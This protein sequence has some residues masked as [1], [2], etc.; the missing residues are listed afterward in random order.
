MGKSVCFLFFISFFCILFSLHA[1]II[2]PPAGSIT[3]DVLL[4]SSWEGGAQ[5]SA[6]LHNNAPDSFTNVVVRLHIA[7]QEIVSLWDMEIVNQ[8]V[9]FVDLSF[10]AWKTSLSENDSHAFGFV[11]S[12]STPPRI[13]VISGTSPTSDPDDP[14]PSPLPS[15]QNENL[16]VQ[17]LSPEVQLTLTIDSSWG[18]GTPWSGGSFRATLTN[19]SA[20]GVDN[21]QLLVPFG[22]QISFWGVNIVSQTGSQT[23]IALPDYQPYIAPHASFDFGF[24]IAPLDTPAFQLV[25]VSTLPTPGTSPAPPVLQ[26]VAIFYPPP[27]TVSSPSFTKTTSTAE[28]LSQLTA[29]ESSSSYYQSSLLPLSP[30]EEMICPV[31]NVSWGSTYPSQI[32]IGRPQDGDG[33]LLSNTPGTTLRLPDKYFALFL[34]FAETIYGLNPHFLMG[35]AAKESFFGALP[36]TDDDSYF[37]V[38]A[39]DDFFVGNLQMP[40]SE[41]GYFTDG[42]GDGPFQVETPSLSTLISAFPHRLDIFSACNGNS[43]EACAFRG[44]QQGTLVGSNQLDYGFLKEGLLITTDNS[45]AQ[46]FY[47]TL[48]RD[49][50]DAVVQDY[51]TAVIVTALDLRYRYHALFGLPQMGFR[52]AYDSRITHDEKN[53]LEFA[54]MLW[55]YNRGLFTNINLQACLPG[56]DPISDC[57]LDGYGGHSQNIREACRFLNHAVAQEEIYDFP[58]AREDVSWFLQKLQLTYP[59]DNISGLIPDIDWAQAESEALQSFDFLLTEYQN[60]QNDPTLHTLSFRYHWRTIL[61]VIRSHL[62]EMENAMG[63]TMQDMLRYYGDTLSPDAS[64]T[65]W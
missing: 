16:L 56:M 61:M 37:V 38:D 28:L 29:L 32:I 51:Y 24:T 62:P 35:L 36:N 60:R 27:I 22:T 1:Q 44:L 21:L 43:A 54:A 58:I 53:E 20:Q 42:N 8:D 64:L 45:L 34:G 33:F 15:P 65:M 5:Y 50:H 23:E 48:L 55:S 9:D 7:P 63:P 40:L 4:S 57:G 49:F 10:P 47:G 3:S 19:Q 59:F 30:S 13:S 41:R 17:T 25:S 18:E 6:S 14:S 31:R 2:T 11:L 52:S 39:P 46:P 12:S 26:S